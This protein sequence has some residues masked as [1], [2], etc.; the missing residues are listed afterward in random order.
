MFKGGFGQK[1]WFAGAGSQNKGMGCACRLGS[2]QPGHAKDTMGRYAFVYMVQ[3]ITA[4][5]AIPCK[6]GRDGTAAE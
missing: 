5:H 1:D 3:L 2:V 6:A 4:I